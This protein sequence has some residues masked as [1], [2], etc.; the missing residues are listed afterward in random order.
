M[1]G[2]QQ[3]RQISVVAFGC[4]LVRVF[5]SALVEVRLKILHRFLPGN[6]KSAKIDVEIG[7]S[8]RLRGLMTA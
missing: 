5:A 4:T 6:Q 1:R 2:L 7:N 8:W 3:S